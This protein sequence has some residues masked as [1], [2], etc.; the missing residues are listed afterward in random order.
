MITRIPVAPFMPEGGRK[1]LRLLYQPCG[2][3]AERYVK[4]AQVAAYK[5]LL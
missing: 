4:T 1:Y 5:I 2:K 3:Q